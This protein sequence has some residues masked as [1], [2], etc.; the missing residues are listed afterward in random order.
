MP[1]GK[2]TGQGLS[3]MA[4][5]V[6]LLWGCVLAER[7]VRLSAAARQARALRELKLL[8]ENHFGP[9]PAGLPARFAPTHPW[10]RTEPAGATDRTPVRL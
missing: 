7:S 10:R 9:R 2:I 3:A 8:R 4:V 5:A 1:I 6:A